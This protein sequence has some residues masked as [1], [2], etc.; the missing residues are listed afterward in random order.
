[1]IEFLIFMKQTTLFN[2]LNLASALFLSF[3]NG[4]L[5]SKFVTVK[6]LLN[7]TGG[8]YSFTELGIAWTGVALFWDT[9]SLSTQKKFVN[10]GIFY[11]TSSRSPMEPKPST[12][13][14]AFTRLEFANRYMNGG[15]FIY[16]YSSAYTTPSFMAISK[17]IINLG[18]MWFVI[19]AIV[20][21]SPDDMADVTLLAHEQFRNFGYIEVSGTGS[22]VASLNITQGLPDTSDLEKKSIINRGHILLKQ[23]VWEL[24]TNIRGY[25]CIS[26]TDGAH[27]SLD[28]RIEYPKK[29]KI[30]FDPESTNAT[31]HI[32]VHDGGKLFQQELFGFS[33]N[34]VITFSEDMNFFE[35]HGRSLFFWRGP[36]D[37]AYQFIIGPNYNRL[38]FEWSGRA[39]IYRNA[40]SKVIPQKCDPRYYAHFMEQYLDPGAW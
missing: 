6:D 13:E 26:L 2:A 5:L 29:Q 22:H 38:K 14:R 25:G 11:Q 36:K 34:C 39:L 33:K 27:L 40:A 15:R 7:N 32:H 35:Y 20:E 12:E 24:K 8:H 23:T 17:K 10:H 30:F 1:M 19:G 31:L 4:A 3:V 16:D 37:K 18:D 28:D 9:S 21:Q